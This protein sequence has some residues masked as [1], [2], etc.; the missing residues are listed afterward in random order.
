MDDEF[1][2][3]ELY[4]E[5]QAQAADE[6]EAEPGE[7]EAESWDELEA[8][9]APK[10]V[11]RGDLVE[12]TVAE[13]QD[14][15][16]VLDLGTKY[17]GFV[18][19]SEFI[20]DEELPQVGD[21]IQVA[22]VNVDDKAERIRVS[23]R[24]ADYERA[25]AELE[26]AHQSGETVTGMVTER[27]KGGL[28]VNVGLPGFVPASQVIVRDVRHLDR[29]VGRAL[30]LKVVEVDRRANK[31]ILSHKQA[32]E[33]ERARRREK[34]LARLYEG[35]VCEGRVVSLTDY[36]AFVDLGGVDGL[37]HVSEMA[38]HHVSHPSEVVKRGDI[39]R[40]VVLSIE[41]GGNRISLS[42]REIL[43]D[44]WKE[45]SAKYQEGQ[46]VEV[47]ITRLVSTGA[48]ALPVGVDVEGFIPLREIS[49]QR[50]KKPEEAIRPGQRLEARILDLQ[51]QAH[52]MTLSLTQASAARRRE[53]IQGYLSTENSGAS[54]NLGEQFGAI[55]QAAIAEPAPAVEAAPEQDKPVRKPRARK[56]PPEPEPGPDAEVSACTATRAAGKK[57]A[58]PAEEEAL[59][60][61]EQ[62][63]LE[64]T[65]A[66]PSSGEEG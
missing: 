37:L 23:K 16:L 31:V 14:Q 21:K 43:P 46:T 58:P 5:E 12:A 20:S 63:G 4:D 42:R 55:L 44:P 66:V 9:L 34:T 45:I 47:E 54:I 48:F 60:S 18:P 65:E 53:E 2:A 15:A 41:N 40:V 3:D 28:R 6:G 24:R 57:A 25:W 13:V 39:V 50:I 36:G 8:A 29:F 38:W 59:A 22:V 19:R 64:A 7:S 56:K 1:Q 62:P 26:A 32:V 33:E 10:T 49:E 52:K 35:A 17:E 51:P 27:V 30:P 61:A 11:K